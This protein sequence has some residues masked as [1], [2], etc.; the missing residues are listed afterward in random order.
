MRPILTDALR[1]VTADAPLNANLRRFMSDILSAMR[2]V[3]FGVHPSVLPAATAPT[4]HVYFPEE[5]LPVGSIRYE[6]GDGTYHVTSPA[7]ANARFR[8]GTAARHT[9]MSKHLGTAVRNATTYLRRRSIVDTAS[10]LADEARKAAQ[11]HAHNHH[12]EF[13]RET[14]RLFGLHPPVA[15]S[16]PIAP[17]FLAEL[18][19]LLDID[20]KFRDAAFASDLA[21]WCA[22]ASP[23]GIVWPGN[24]TYVHFRDTPLGAYAN[25]QEFNIGSYT[26]RPVGDSRSVAAVDLPPEL[27]GPA[28]ALALV[29]PGTYVPGVGYR[30]AKSVYYVVR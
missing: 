24:A 11:E 18:R 26:W 12:M 27:A 10:T 16:C 4:I 1:P 3:Q 2:T 7:I 13:R 19:H 28:A 8:S 5:P 17:S 6:V 30:R 15:S 25:V 20:H 22:A 29:D 14:E 23:H 9:K 21:A